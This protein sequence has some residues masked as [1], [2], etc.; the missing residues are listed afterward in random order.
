MCNGYTA[1]GFLSILGVQSH[2][3]RPNAAYAVVITDVLAGDVV[4]AIPGSA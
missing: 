2:D 1:E 3:L 4:P